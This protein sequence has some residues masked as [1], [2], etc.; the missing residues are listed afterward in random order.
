MVNVEYNSTIIPLNVGVPL[1]SPVSTWPHTSGTYSDTGSTIKSAFYNVSQNPRI[2]IKNTYVGKSINCYEIHNSPDTPLSSVASNVFEVKN[3]QRSG[4]FST[5]VL[6]RVY[7]F[8]LN[9]ESYLEVSAATKGNRICLEGQGALTTLISGSTLDTA[10]D[11]FVVIN[12]DDPLNHH[13][14]KITELHTYEVFG[15]G[16][17]FEP[18]YHKEVP[19]GTKISIYKGPDSTDT[20]IVAVGYGLLGDS[21]TSDERHDSYVEVSRPTFYFY[22]DRCDVNKLL[23]DTKY[24]VTK[25]SAHGSGD[26]F[27]GGSLTF[28]FGKKQSTAHS[29]FHLTTPDLHKFGSSICFKTTSSHG[30]FIQDK[31]RYSQFGLLKDNLKINDETITQA[32]GVMK[33]RIVSNG[34]VEVYNNP[35]IDYIWNTQPHSETYDTS[36]GEWDKC[37]KNINRDG[38]HLTTGL[39]KESYDSNIKRYVEYENSDTKNNAIPQVSNI[40]IY[41]SIVSVGNFIEV[42]IPDPNRIVDLKIK[43]YDKVSLREQL[44]DIDY[45]GRMSIPLIGNA[46]SST[47]GWSLTIKGL[48]PNQDLRTIWGSSDVAALNPDGVA[49]SDNLNKLRIKNIIFMGDFNSAPVQGDDGYEQVFTITHRR[50]VNTDATWVVC[51]GNWSLEDFVNETAFVYTYNGR[52]KLF[53]T[54]VQIDTEWDGT[55]LKR[56]GNIVGINDSYL[57]NTEFFVRD[58]DLTGFR[59][60]IKY[61][62]KNLNYLK[63]LYDDYDCYQIKTTVRGNNSI[64]NVPN[65]YEYINGNIIY[66][67]KLFEGNVEY[68]EDEIQ[69]SGILQYK[70]K[71]RDRVSD[72]LDIVVNHNFTHTSDYIYTTNNPTN[73]LTTVIF[74]SNA[75]TVNIKDFDYGDTVISL[76]SF[77]SIISTQ[78]NIEVGDTL[79]CNING[80]CRL[81]GIIQSI[82]GETAVSGT[83][84]NGSTRT[85]IPQPNNGYNITLTEATNY[86]SKNKTYGAD[87]LRV[88]KK[89]TSL[90]KALS[91]NLSNNIRPT[92]LEGCSN[93]GLLFVDGN[94]INLTSGEKIE[95]LSNLS[96]IDSE[97]SQGFPISNIKGNEISANLPDYKFNITTDIN[98]NIIKKY[99]TISSP[100]EMGVLKIEALENKLSLITLAPIFPVVLAKTAENTLDTTLTNSQGLYFVNTQGLSNGGFLHYLSSETNNNGASKTFTNPGYIDD[101]TDVDGIDYRLED[102]YGTFIWRYIGLQE[103]D[104]TLV[105][106]NAMIDRVW[107]VKYSQTNRELN[108]MYGNKSPINGYASAVRIE[109][110][111]VVRNWDYQSVITQAWLKQNSPEGREGFYNIEGSRFWD[112]LKMPN[113]IRNQIAGFGLVLNPTYAFRESSLR[114]Y[115]PKLST[116]IGFPGDLI[117]N[118]TGTYYQYRE[119]Y[120]AFDKG[121]ENFYLFSTGDIYPDSYKRTNSIGFTNRN[122]SDYGIIF[123][124]K[125]VKGNTIIEHSNYKGTIVDTLESDTSYEI[126]PINNSNKNT[127]ELKRMGLMRL[128]EV[129]YDWHFNE[130]DYENLDDIVKSRKSRFTTEIKPLGDYVEFFPGEIDM[131]KTSFGNPKVIG[132]S[133]DGSTQANGE[134]TES[135]SLNGSALP[136]YII[137]EGSTTIP[138]T[139]S[140]VMDFFKI[141]T[142]YDNFDTGSTNLLGTYQAQILGLTNIEGGYRTVNTGPNQ[143][144]LQGS[145]HTETGIL[146]GNLASSVTQQPIGGTVGTYTAVV[147][148]TNNTNRA[149]GFICDITLDSP[150]NVSSIVFHEESSSVFIG[151]N[152]HYKGAHYQAGDTVTIAGS[153]VG[154][155]QDII[156]TLQNSDLTTEHRIYLF[157]TGQASGQNNNAL[158]YEDVITGTNIKRCDYTGLLKMTADGQDEPQDIHSY[159]VRTNEGDFIANSIAYTGLRAENYFFNYTTILGALDNDDGFYKGV[160]EDTAITTQTDAEKQKGYHIFIPYHVTGGSRNNL[161]ESVGALPLKRGTPIRFGSLLPFSQGVDVDLRSTQGNTTKSLSRVIDAFSEWDDG[162]QTANTRPVGYAPSHLYTDTMLVIK[163]LKAHNHSMLGQ[164]K[165]FPMQNAHIYGDTTSINTKI[166][167]EE[168]YNGSTIPNLHLSFCFTDSQ[169]SFPSILYAYNFTDVSQ[170]PNRTT[171]GFESTGTQAYGSVSTNNHRFLS[172]T[173]GRNV[174]DDRGNDLLDKSDQIYGAEILFKLNLSLLASNVSVIELDNLSQTSGSLT[175]NANGSTTNGRAVIKIEQ[176]DI[177]SEDGFST[178]NAGTLVNVDVSSS[179]NKI[180]QWVNFVNDLTG[181]YLVSEQDLSNNDIPLYIH[182]RRNDVQ[183]STANLIHQVISHNINHNGTTITHYIEIDNVPYSNGSHQLYNM[184]RVMRIAKDCTFDFTPNDVEMYKLSNRFTRMPA[185]NKC[186]TLVGNSNIFPHRGAASTNLTAC[187][188]AVLSMYVGLDVDGKPNSDYIVKRVNN[189]FATVDGNNNTFIKNKSYNCLVTDGITDLNKDL[190]FTGDGSLSNPDRIVFSGQMKN[191]KGIVSIGE[192]FSVTTQ[193]NPINNTVKRCNIASTVD[194]V[195]EVDEITNT[196]LETNNIQ[197][198]PEYN[199]TNDLYYIGNNYIGNNAFSVINRLLNYKNKRLYIDGRNIKGLDNIPDEWKTNIVLSENDV[200]SQVSNIKRI[201]S[202]FDFFNHVVVYGDGVKGTGRNRQSIKE[203]DRTITKEITDLTIKT[204]K[205]ADDLAISTVETLDSLNSQVEFQ[206][207]R[208]KIPYLKAGH[209]ITLDY[210]TQKIPTNFYQ[211]LEIQTIFGQLPKVIL[212][213]YSQSLAGVYT[214]IIIKNQE[215]DGQLRGDNF[216]DETANVSE[217]DDSFIQPMKLKITKTTTASSSNSTIGFNNLIGFNSSVGFV[218]TSSSSQEVILDEDLTG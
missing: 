14:A 124:S 189:S 23:G 139:V 20:H 157:Q 50:N 27:T 211:V 66:D 9:L 58:R 77:D 6:N 84:W 40:D 57:S 110:D 113:E 89:T 160:Y 79:F 141:Y 153:A 132:F 165:G 74:N 42:N 155:S 166:N 102:N 218:S 161:H 19:K 115:Y 184:Y 13:I 10:S 109:Y 183:E 186:Y 54:N 7:P 164:S 121:I 31:S 99:D 61:G 97:F 163:R 148:T 96:A 5:S 37:F 212:G 22:E 45:E 39:S 129:T 127:S 192:A 46:N 93:K 151:K 119:N 125:G 194:I 133:I 71:G 15:D 1:L 138:N 185:E 86:S 188:E 12:A 41:E 67:N 28:D 208:F 90:G 44:D 51:T 75:N 152:I 204:Q 4:G 143:L 206:I 156:I 65:L 33:Q 32:S 158:N 106:N 21:T 11:Y 196:I 197:F 140:G 195:E 116:R 108:H 98:E 198:N 107:N 202:T 35:N 105:W 168:I 60:P 34:A 182:S 150:T 181:H 179:F 149:R 78:T 120:E 59:I 137:E 144:R 72:V 114:S 47:T 123:K 95:K 55:N 53:N 174:V 52:T 177:A 73:D 62:D 94:S 130:V 145:W 118:L 70:F 69:P 68:L 162:T 17:D 210:P 112:I 80:K 201:Q 56:D 43:P 131:L 128:I 142:D 64:V 3:I 122:L 191:L 170:Y 25:T 167:T 126:M 172:S 176:V 49:H 175:L 87:N 81:I 213:K 187:N 200:D 203:T 24:K 92:S 178:N 76:F 2:I 48:S 30:N 173:G 29:L 216:T 171:Y 104:S 100:T 146:A 63:P 88:S 91:S 217:D 207:P 147:T 83:Y 135:G 101:P 82:S 193:R 103:S 18:A 134:Y 8:N 159:E 136:Y 38:H 154:S 169:S 209:I 214:D 111:G 16:F 190:L 26:P 180:N 215:T 85:A 117:N 205:A 36:L 199:V